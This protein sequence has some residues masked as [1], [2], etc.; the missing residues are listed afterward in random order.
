MTK[1][2]KEILEKAYYELIDCPRGPREGERFIILN[3]WDEK[4]KFIY[5][6]FE[7]LIGYDKLKELY[8][9]R[10]KFEKGMITHER[11]G[12]HPADKKY[13]GTFDEESPYEIPTEITDV[14]EKEG[15]IDEDCYDVFDEIVGQWGFYDEYDKC[16]RCHKVVRTR[17]NSYT[18]TPESVLLRGELACEE[19]VKE[20][21]DIKQE[22]ISSCLNKIEAM[23]FFKP[24]EIGFKRVE[25]E[26]SVGLYHWSDDDPEKVISELNDA[27]IDVLFDVYPSQFAEDFEV[28]VR[29]EQI[30]EAREILGVAR[31]KYD[32]G[33]SP[34]EKM[35]AGLNELNNMPSSKGTARLAHVG[36]DGLKVK[37]VP[38]GVLK[39]KGIKKCMEEVH[40]EKEEK[41]DKN[42]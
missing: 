10:K 14:L 16:D 6:L 24:E 39:K 35:K 28:L 3:E 5:V 30:E 15:L 23:L 7:G 34:A 33:Q 11:I 22:Y 40:N 19:C 36:K 12:Q 25:K 41:Y 29:E 2:G 9:H 38:H 31:V 18:W 21:E 27:G 4:Y 8:G 17:P 42:N 37:D 26:Y 32:T 1:K 20:D 13:D